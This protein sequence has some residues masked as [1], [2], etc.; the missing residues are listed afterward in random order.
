[1]HR[2]D[3]SCTEW[4][5]ALGIF[6]CAQKRPHST[7]LSPVR[8]TVRVVPSLQRLVCVRHWACA[9]EKGWGH[10]EAGMESEEGTAFES[11]S[12][13]KPYGELRRRAK[14]AELAD[15]ADLESGPHLRIEMQQAALSN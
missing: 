5:S 4:D 2:R 15:A 3:K 14:M 8:D 12:S 11:L 9:W 6:S 10:G 7:P 13:A 1:M